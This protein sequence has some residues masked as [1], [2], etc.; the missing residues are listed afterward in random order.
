MA[1]AQPREG[2]LGEF[3]KFIGPGATPAELRLQFGIALIAPILLVLYVLQNDLDWTVFQLMIGVIL[4]L[5]MAGGVVTNAT[6]AAKRWYHRRGQ[7]F[8]Q[9][10][11]FVMVHIIQPLL[12]AFVFRDQDLV[13]VMV[14]FGYLMIASVTILKAP[15]YLQRPVAMVFLMGGFL[16]N[17][18]VLVP[19]NGLEWFIPMYYT[20]LLVS[21]LLMETAY[22]PTITPDIETS[23]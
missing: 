8:R 18:Y 14:I 1:T 13:Y 12:I 21:H 6:S 16:M 15:L 19:T 7:G 22:T 4:V 5:D 3:D 10:M 11:L 20:K 23:G 9:H 2:M 17:S